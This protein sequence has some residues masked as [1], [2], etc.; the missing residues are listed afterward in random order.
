MTVDPRVGWSKRRRAAS[1]FGAWSWWPA[2]SE[3]TCLSPRPPKHTRH[4]QRRSLE[5]SFDWPARSE[6]HPAFLLV[7]YPCCACTACLHVHTSLSPC[8]YTPP[9]SPVNSPAVNTLYQLALLT[10][11]Q[12]RTVSAPNNKSPKHSPCPIPTAP[13]PP[14]P[15]P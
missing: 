12:Q 8:N 2:R 11:S 3:S 1:E 5:H 6:S 9:S 4:A 14:N 7:D 15:T 10:V 13:P